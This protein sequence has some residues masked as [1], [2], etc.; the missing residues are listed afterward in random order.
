MTVYYQFRSKGGLLEALFDSLASHRLSS[1]LVDAMDR[2][3][4]A[5]GLQEFVTAIAGFWDEDR[6]I[7]TRLQGLA[8]LDPDFGQIWRQREGFRR[9]GLAVLAGRLSEQLRRP[10]SKRL[11]EVVDAL[12]ALVSFET[13]NALAGDRRSFTQV[14]PL[15][16]GLA[17]AIF[18]L[19]ALQSRTP[20]RFRSPAKTEARAR[21]VPSKPIRTRGAA[22]SLRRSS[23]AVAGS[24]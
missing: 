6:V 17:R 2:T 24:P 1:Q 23:T 22:S 20:V 13:F 8:T 11:G 12:Y 9:Q 16:A 18:D 15:V 19:A 14:A 21:S 7:I 10:P 3:D 5:A 4:P